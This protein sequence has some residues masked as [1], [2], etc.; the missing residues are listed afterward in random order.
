MGYAD[1]TEEGPVGPCLCRAPYHGGLGSP[2]RT[3]PG[4]PR[5]PRALAARPVWPAQ[6][7]LP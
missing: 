7:V 4:H 3:L 1:D 5:A 2:P 6:R